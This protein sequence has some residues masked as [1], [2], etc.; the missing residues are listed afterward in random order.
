MSIIETSLIP[1]Q[2]PENFIKRNTL[3]FSE[4]WEQIF[5]KSLSKDKLYAECRAGRIPHI[6]IGTKIIFRRNTLEAWI[7]E[8]ELENCK[9]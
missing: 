1:Q 4:A 6:R 9:N 5:E 2:S 7:T 3:T 8:K